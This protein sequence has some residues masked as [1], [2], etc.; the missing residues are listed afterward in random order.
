MK[1]LVIFLMIIGL[2]YGG[3]RFFLSIASNYLAQQVA[4]EIFVD[5]GMEKLL[6]NPQVEE[7]LENYRSQLDTDEAQRNL[8]F[9]TKE[10]ATKVILS[11]F[12]VGEI[13]D[14]T[15]K[16]TRGLT[17]TEQQNLEAMVMDRLTTD[18]LEALLLVGIS[19]VSQELIQ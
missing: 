5:G 15:S 10:E 12:S 1:K 16:A 17:L 4:N 18:E 8:P 19:E 13:R 7:V 6:E 11:K 3:Y 14:I 9:S 2:L